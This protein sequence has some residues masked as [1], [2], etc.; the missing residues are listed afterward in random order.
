M[1]S[2]C[3]WLSRQ[4]NTLKVSSSSLDEIIH[5]PFCLWLFATGFFTPCIGS[6]TLSYFEQWRGVFF[7][8]ML[9]WGLSVIGSLSSGPGRV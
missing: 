8:C 1:V 4:S 2:W 3:S 6:T 7:P 5:I 9:S